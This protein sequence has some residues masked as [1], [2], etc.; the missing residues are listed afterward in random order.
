MRTPIR[1]AVLLSIACITPA[2]G[3]DKAVPKQIVISKDMKLSEALRILRSEGVQ[4]EELFRAVAPADP[5]MLLKEFLV[6]PQF[7]NGDAL[8]ISAQ[9]ADTGDPNYVVT[10][11]E[12]DLNYVEDCKF[13]YTL[14]ADKVLYLDRLNV[15]VLKDLPAD[16]K[17]QRKNYK[18][19]DPNDD[20][21]STE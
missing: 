8:I 16:V 2:Y 3:A 20:P 1:F 10:G 15:D 18:P 19:P 11:L 21:F 7:R 6:Y 9:A 4:A 12:W 14:R 13:P 5:K 17:N